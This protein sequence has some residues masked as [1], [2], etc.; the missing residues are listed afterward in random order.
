V[1]GITTQLIFTAIGSGYEEHKSFLIKML[2][3]LLYVALPLALVTFVLT[4]F[5]PKL[6][7]LQMVLTMVLWCAALL[8]NELVDGQMPSWLHFGTGKQLRNET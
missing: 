3:T 7:I 6:W 1:F 4:Q 5:L 2:K 8:G